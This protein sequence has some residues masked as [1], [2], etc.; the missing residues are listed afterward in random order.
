M[1][2]LRRFRPADLD[3]ERRDGKDES[4]RSSQRSRFIVDVPKDQLLKVEVKLFD[5][6]TMGADFPGDKSGRYDVRVRLR[7]KATPAGQA[8]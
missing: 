3:A 4:F 6:S 7:A 8:P 1:E 5:D 2:E